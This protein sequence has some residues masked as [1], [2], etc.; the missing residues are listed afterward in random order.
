MEP[1][2]TAFLDEGVARR[3]EDVRVNSL[4]VGSSVG[5]FLFEGPSACY[6]VPLKDSG[7]ALLGQVGTFLLIQRL[8]LSGNEQ[9]GFYIYIE[10]CLVGPSAL[11]GEVS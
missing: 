7:K 9:A 11:M 5:D 3:G 4:V 8:F 2:D 6:S 10:V 1:G